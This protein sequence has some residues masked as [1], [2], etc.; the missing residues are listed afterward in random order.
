MTSHK[1]IGDFCGDFC[2]HMTSVRKEK[3]CFDL[4][5]EQ[6]EKPPEKGDFIWVT[7]VRLAI[8]QDELPSWARE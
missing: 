2:E 1:D 3:F 6:K 8:R 7:S 5:F 4:I